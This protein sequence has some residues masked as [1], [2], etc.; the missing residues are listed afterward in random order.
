MSVRLHAEELTLNEIAPWSLALQST[1]TCSQITR[2]SEEREALVLCQGASQKDE[3][4]NLYLDGTY[5]HRCPRTGALPAL[6]TQ[7]AVVIGWSENKN[8]DY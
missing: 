5:A 6:A 3:L 7:T 1:A 4:I 8:G 2:I